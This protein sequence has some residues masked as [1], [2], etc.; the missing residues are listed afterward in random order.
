MPT[1]QPLECSVESCDYQTPMG[2]PTWDHMVT[3]LTQHSNCVHGSPSNSSS[4]NM[5]LEKLPRPTFNLNMTESQWSFTKIQWDHYINQVQVPEATKLTQLQA[6]CSETLRQ[7]IFDTGLYDTLNTPE[8]FL[9]QMETLAVIKVHKSVHL[10]NLWRMNQQVDEPIRAFVARL[11]ATADMCNMTVVC[12]C[13]RAVTYRDNVIQQLVI[14][15][16]YD[17][18]IRIRVMSRNTNG[19]LTT[20]DKLVNYIQAEEAGRNESNDLISEDGQVASIKKK[21]SYQVDKG[22]CGHCGQKRHTSNNSPED[23]KSS[24]KAYGV[25]CNKCQRKHH[26]ASVCR[27]KNK[28]SAIVETNDNQDAEISQV[29]SFFSLSAEVQ[30]PNIDELSAVICHLKDTSNGPVTTLP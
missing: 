23:R 11:T 9:K 28:V 4:Q 24:C 7:R 25:T 3:L 10:R 29:A 8:L 19:E 21:S 1:P 26:Y 2:C 18:D 14:H 27:S 22:K 20:L 30:T 5:K 17:N 6:A 16:M 13:N 15:G 12:E